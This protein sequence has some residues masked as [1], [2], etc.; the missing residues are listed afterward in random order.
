MML[1]VIC[2]VFDTEA[3]LLQAAVHSVLQQ[4]NGPDLELVLVDDGSTHPATLASL[5]ALTSSESRVT[6]L[7]STQNRGPAGARNLG[8]HHAKGDWIGFIDAD[9]LWTAGRLARAMDILRQHPNAEWIGGAEATLEADGE[10]R[11]RRP[12]SCVPTVV[13]PHDVAAP[14]ETPALTR[15]FILEGMH[16][17]A[18][19]IRRSLAITAGY[20][21]QRIA[22]GEDWVFLSR[23]SLHATM[24]YDRNPCY[25]LRR[26][27][28]SM[29]R[30]AGRLS[31]KYA[32]GQRIALRDARLGA[33]RRELRWALYRV[34]KDLAMNNRLNGNSLRAFSFACRAWLVDPR[35]VRDVLIFVRTLAL[36][37][38]AELTGELKR[39]CTAEMV[40][41]DPS[42]FEPSDGA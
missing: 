12:M 32:S 36:P 14:I 1:S 35:E 3:A 13:G 20:F 21:D 22:Y 33:F 23:I 26:Q 4:K 37:E 24:Y 40:I 7:R 34:Y 2:P 42:R 41:L 18:N 6:M 38:S 27:G 30:S 11:A 19:L 15:S 8:I 16:L 39:Y 5:A 29:M 28:A 10:T 9:D 25:I 31:I 17:G